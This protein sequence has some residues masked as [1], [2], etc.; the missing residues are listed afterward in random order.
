MAKVDSYEFIGIEQTHDLEVDHPDH[1]FYL[2]NGMLTSNSHAVAY[3]FDSFISAWLL[4]YYPSEWVASY[5]ETMVKKGPT[6]RAKAIAEA[7]QLGFKIKKVD[8]N[9]ATDRWSILSKKRLMPSLTTI[10]FVG[11]SALA[12]IIANRPY[13]TARDLLWN[14]DGSKRHAKFTKRALESLIKIGAFDSMGIVG[15]NKTFSSYRHM[16]H[17][18]I[19][20]HGILM[21][22]NGAALFDDLV[23]DTREIDDWTRHEKIEFLMELIG[24][25][26]IELIVSEKS[27]STLK[28]KEVAPIDSLFDDDLESAKAIV[29]FVITGVDWKTTKNKKEYAELHVLGETS[30]P[31]NVRCWGAN[32]K[33]DVFR[34]YELYIA[35]VEKN[36]F[37]YST[38][39]WNIKEIQL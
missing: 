30:H 12:E 31:V 5:I 8:I 32:S 36:N 1:Q 14:P 9:I 27:I 16:H 34:Q 11:K 38:R 10:N 4:T 23:R 21:K 33:R 35:E 6:G 29:W 13:A 15:K 25:V 18:M 22:K 17:V 19:E 37:G 3:A 39:T 24:D 26:D 7:K 2:A 20:N 28:K